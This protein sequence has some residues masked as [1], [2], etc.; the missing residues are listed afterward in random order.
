LIQLD[1]TAP[2]VSIEI[3]SGAGNCG[4]FAPGA[5]L[6]GTFVARDDYLSHYALG[7]EPAIN[8][9]GVGVPVPSGGSVNTAIAPGDPWTLDTTGMMP[10]G[11]IIRVV[12]VDR[13]ILNSQSVGHHSPDS[14]GF[15]LDEEQNS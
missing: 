9:P 2:E 1:N 12:A 5:V 10:C 3:T 13:A 7:V 11:Y 15:C 6:S 4:K 14:A 8:P